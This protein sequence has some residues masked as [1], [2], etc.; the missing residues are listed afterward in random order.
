MNFRV[1]VNHYNCPIVTSYAENIKNNVEEL[2]DESIRFKNPFFAFTNEDVLAQGLV[3]A[4]PD[5]PAA[6]IRA[7]AHEGWEELG[8]MRED[9]RRKGEE[10]LKWMKDNNRRGIVL[11]GRPY[12][13]DPEIHHGIPDTDQLLRY[14][15]PDRGFHLPSASAGASDPCQR[16]VDVPY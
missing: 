11:A 2:R 4:F 10:T 6:E 14:G 15:C 7:A 16:P 8:N 3:D 13:V 12:H 9:I 1:P 5:I